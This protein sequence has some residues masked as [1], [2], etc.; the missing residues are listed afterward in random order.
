MK[1][2]RI[3]WGGIGTAALLAITFLFIR[4]SSQSQ[5]GS[6]QQDQ[7]QVVTAF[8]GDLAAGT[9]ASGQVQSQRE[10]VL[11]VEIPG[12]VDQVWVQSGDFVT[13][14]EALVQLDTA[15]LQIAVQRAELVVTLAEANL[16]DLSTPPKDTAVASARSAVAAAQARLDEL[17]AGP[18]AEEIAIA[19]ASV[20]ASE[21]N[22]AA[23]L[24]ELGAAQ[25]SVTEAQIRAAE[26][27][28]LSAQLQLDAAVEINEADPTEQTHLARQ[29]AAQAYAAAK[30][31][32]DKLLAGPDTAAAQSSV[33]GSSARL[34]GSR[35][36][37][38]ATLTGATAVEIANA[39]ATLAQAK[40]SLAAL[41]EPASEEAVA[42]ARAEMEQAR[43]TLIDAQESLAA[44]T[45]AAPFD[46]VVTAVYVQEGELASGTVVEL[47]DNNQMEVV[48][49]VDEVD[50]GSFAIGQPA[51][52]TLEAWPDHFIDAEITFISPRAQRDNNALVTYE[53][54][55][56]M[57]QS[58][59]QILSGMT[60]NANL[61]TS[62]RENVL[63][64]PNAAITPDRRAGTFSVTLRQADGTS[65]EVPVT[66]GLRDSENTEILSGLT[67]GDELVIE[68]IQA[69]ELDFGGP[70]GGPFGG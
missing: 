58:D 4:F 20:R 26:A 45:I 49:Q 7:T 59:L 15:V 44:A 40:A 62:Q 12:Q 18:T 57:T 24:A 29:N 16:A 56:A 69:D 32:L 67:A 6:A 65:Q 54:Y 42:S 23:S 17:L 5:A 28:L 37:S 11:S 55:L 50:I 31:Q 25:G 47:V 8:I 43:L 70:G 61:I 48:L 9:T 30:A 1:K 14:G 10:A 51:V 39:E 68:A 52:V 19:E 38:A 35:A 53:V 46:G 66:I 33:T 13:S 36:N 27:A 22:V 3:I 64:V 60:A 63:L 34:D 2:K 21:A 41:L